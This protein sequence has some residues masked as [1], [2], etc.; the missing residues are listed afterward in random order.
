MAKARNGTP[1]TTLVISTFWSLRLLY[2]QHRLLPFLACAICNTCV[3]SIKSQLPVWWYHFLPFH[4]NGTKWQNEITIACVISMKSQL[5]F[6]CCDFLPFLWN[7]TITQA[8][9]HHG[10]GKRW[11]CTITQVI[12]ISCHFFE[13]APS[14][15]YCTMAQVQNGKVLLFFI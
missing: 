3:I 11:Y 1:Q 13:M 2:N 9:W 6:H 10:T 14:H 15:R 12:V 8:P 4:W 5:P 7:G